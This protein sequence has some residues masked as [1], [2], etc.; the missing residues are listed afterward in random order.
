MS[1]TMVLGPPKVTFGDRTAES[2]FWEIGPPKVTFGGRTPESYFF[3]AAESYFWRIGPPKATFSGPP[4]AARTP[5]SYFLA[6][7][8]DLL[9]KGGFR[10]GGGFGSGLH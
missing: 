8:E 4:E 2:N 5:E 6:K 9:T 10:V 3:G 7:S 1:P